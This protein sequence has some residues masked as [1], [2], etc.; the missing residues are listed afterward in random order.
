MDIILY[1]FEY[2]K[3]Q[4]KIICQLLNFI[5][6][7]IPLKQ[8]AFDD[9]HSPKYQKFKIDELPKIVFFKQDWEWTDLISYYK[10]RYNKNIKPVFRHGECDIP[11]DCRCLLC[12]APFQY[13]MWNN[14]KKKNQLL[15]KVCQ[16]RFSPTDNSRFSKTAVLRCP[17]CS[18]TLVHKKDRKHFIIHKCVNSKCPYYLYNLKKVDKKDLKED[19][20]KNKYKL[21]YIYREFTIDFFKMDLNSL[22]K[23]ASSL[24]FSKFDSNVMS[25]CLTL[26][27]N[28]GLSLRKTR[29]ALKDLYNISISHQMIAN[30]CKTAAV[31]I[32]PFVDHYDYNPCSTF[33]ADD[34]Y[35]NLRRVKSY[36]WFI[37]DAAKRSIIGYQVSDNR[38]VGP[39]ILA[40]SQVEL[41]RKLSVS[42]QTISNWENNNIT[43][44]MDLLCMISRFFSCSAD[45]LLEIDSTLNII[46]TKDLTPKQ[47]AHIQEIVKDMQELNRKINKDLP[48]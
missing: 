38:G 21:H 28:L 11:E 18:H 26:H 5:C 46:E 19:Y 33:T 13:L 16:N 25:L 1:F 8:W 15:C 3:Y 32:T 2:I 29:Q 20:G 35:I 10:Q 43:P 42:K 22:P 39:C 48:S 9:S 47:I 31:C 34:T 4:Q 37:M 30:Y 40:L 14:G 41:A 27:I 44:S 6:R 17:H 36:I 23:N 24:K 7:Y 12:N 45:Y